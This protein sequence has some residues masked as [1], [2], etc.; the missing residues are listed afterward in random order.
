M[1]D[2]WNISALILEGIC[3]AGK[4]TIFRSLLQSERFVQKS[5]L[6]SIVL[7]E[8]QTQRVLERKERET[9][10]TPD[11]NVGLLDQHV[12]YLEAVQHR[13]NQMEWCRNNRTNMRVP[14]V[15]ERFHF[16]HVYHYPHMTW[17]H[18]QPID[19]RLAE[20]NC[21]VCL[22]T[23]PDELLRERI[24]TNRDS[25]WREY[26][27]RYGKTDEEILRYYAAQ[28]QRLRGLCETSELETLVLDASGMRVDD[29]VNRVLDFWGAI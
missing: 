6:S 28:Q 13:L 21:K 7:S 19:H 18:V 1:K 25:G 24:I 9:G 8:H 29:T 11:D 26:L 27:S 2:N 15:L 14:C 10:L 4:T 3:G 16:T 17:E 20:L 5:F 12:S 22:L 23:I